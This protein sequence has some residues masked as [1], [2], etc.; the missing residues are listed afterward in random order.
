[1]LDID[2]FDRIE[3]DKRYNHINDI[4]SDYINKMSVDI[5]TVNCISYITK[6]NIP[7]KIEV[8]IDLIYKNENLCWIFH[9]FIN[10]QCDFNLKLTSDILSHLQNDLY[11]RY[12]KLLR[13][14]KINKLTI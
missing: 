4:L 13:M 9:I 14:Y 2:R 10:N 8:E 5:S 3:G 1:M 6:H 12:N 7:T 11:N